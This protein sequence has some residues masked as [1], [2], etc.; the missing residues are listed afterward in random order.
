MRDEDR[1]ALAVLF[2]PCLPL[3]REVL[4]ALTARYPEAVLTVQRSQLKIGPRAGFCQLW[5]SGRR[6]MLTFGLRRAIIHPRIRHCA[7]PTPTR[8][9]Y[10]VELQSA[11]DLDEALFLWLDEAQD[12]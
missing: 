4:D 10:H 12:G 2:E 5:P 9:T 8:W 3:F 6:L 11:E 1:L 7:H